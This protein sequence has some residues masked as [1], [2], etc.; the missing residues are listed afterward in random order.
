MEMNKPAYGESVKKTIETTKPDKSSPIEALNLSPGALNLCKI[1]NIETIEDAMK[2]SFDTSNLHG[3]WKMYVKSLIS[4]IILALKACGYNQKDSYIGLVELS[5][6][7]S[8]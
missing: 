4:E 1:L 2:P 8:E 7:S 6:K 5:R 3:L